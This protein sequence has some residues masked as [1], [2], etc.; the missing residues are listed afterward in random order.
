MKVASGFAAWVVLQKVSSTYLTVVANE[1][2]GSFRVQRRVFLEPHQLLAGQRAER[3]SS[4]PTCGPAAPCQVA[5]QG[6][7]FKGSVFASVTKSKRFS[8]IFQVVLQLR[9][10]SF[11]FLC[12]IKS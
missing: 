2:E 6:F 8:R 10:G 5:L 7:R 3:R 12:E 9:Y 4:L 11:D 1:D